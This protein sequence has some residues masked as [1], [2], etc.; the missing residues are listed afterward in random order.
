MEKPCRMGLKCSVVWREFLETPA[1]S[2]F[3]AAKEAR[4]KL[5]VC[6]QSLWH[7][8]NTGC[9]SVSM[10]VFVSG[11]WKQA[12]P[13]C[14]SVLLWGFPDRQSQ[15]S[16]TFPALCDVWISACYVGNSP[17]SPKAHQ[18]PSLTC[19]PQTASPSLSTRTPPTLECLALCS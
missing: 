13:L 11:V 9:Q 17:K 5:C 3:L 4:R 1:D 8:S 6:G 18:H 14:S 16:D 10:L 19:L 7:I 2:R 12:W 15:C